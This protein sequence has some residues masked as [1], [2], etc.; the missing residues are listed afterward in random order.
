MNIKIKRILAAI[1]DFY[2]ICFLSSVV[3]FV[4]TLGRFNVTMFSIMLYLILSFAFLIIKDISFKNA[5]LGKQIF[6]LKIIK[7][8]GTKLSAVDVI[9]RNIPL[10]ILMPIE[11]LMIMANNKRV[12]DIWAETIVEK[13]QGDG[14]VVSK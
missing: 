2:V 8:N 5:S 4:F 13:R 1:V 12:G 10:I 11:V 6:K 9:K 7:N 14:S 3:I